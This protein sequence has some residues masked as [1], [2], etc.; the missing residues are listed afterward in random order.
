MRQHEH[1]S[2]ASSRTKLAQMTGG[3][4]EAAVAQHLP[5]DRTQWSCK[6]RVKRCHCMSR[7]LQSTLSGAGCELLAESGPGTARDRVVSGHLT[8]IELER[9][10][11]IRRC[12]QLLVVRVG[13]CMAYNQD[14]SMAC[15]GSMQWGETQSARQK[16]WLE[17]VLLV[18]PPCQLGTRFTTRGTE[19]LPLLSELL[20]CPY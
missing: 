1:V 18:P 7:A 8:L 20:L 16:I 10:C 6:T 3:S 12:V 4:Q 5:P 17:F 14:V 9:V 19:A 2:A 13:L 11:R 15:C